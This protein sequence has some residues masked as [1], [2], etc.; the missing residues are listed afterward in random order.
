MENINDCINEL[1]KQL[2]KGKIQ[3]GYKAI[4]EYMHYFQSY[5]KIQFKD[6]NFPGTFY[7]GYLDMSYFAFI[8]SS[9]I[10]KGLKIA[11]VFNYESFRFEIWLSGY[12]KEIQRKYWEHFN[13][14]KVEGFYIPDTIKGYDSI[15]EDHIYIDTIDKEDTTIEL[16]KRIETFVKT[17]EK[18]IN[19][20]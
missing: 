9:F 10:G 14:K 2:D 20:L 12:N 6:Y 16:V 5:L 13:E 8:P 19:S 3:K 17:I 4:L 1:H 15:V 11:I 7:H 18:D